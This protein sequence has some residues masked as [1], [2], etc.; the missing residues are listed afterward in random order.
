MVLYNLPYYLKVVSNFIDT[1]PAPSDISRSDLRHPIRIFMLC[2]ALLFS[3]F[4]LHI[5]NSTL[6]AKEFMS[7]D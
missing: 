2:N 7:S 3:A 5:S 4:L 6:A 1:P